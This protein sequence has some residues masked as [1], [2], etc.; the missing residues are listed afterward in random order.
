MV[1][2]GCTLPVK[3][4]GCLISHHDS[5]AHEARLY[6]PSLA[7]EVE[8]RVSSRA[9]SWRVGLLFAAATAATVY[10]MQGSPGFVTAVDWY[11]QGTWLRAD[12]HTHTQFSDGAHPVETIVSAAAQHGC[13]VV[14]ITD[15]GDRNL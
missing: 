1:E 10:A 11:G 12:F 14:A 6:S 2:A 4:G 8:P 7:S 5:S 13:D 3:D 15:H 9:S